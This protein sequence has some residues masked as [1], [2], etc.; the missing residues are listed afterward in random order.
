MGNHTDHLEIKEATQLNHNQ[1][2]KIQS[3][4]NHYV[5]HSTATFDIHIPSVAAFSDRMNSIA[6]KYPF[7]VCMQGSEI[8]G[9]AY[10]SEFRSKD[11][12]DKT[13]EL[14]IYLHPEVQGKG[15]G[16]LLMST[17]LQKLKEKEF[18]TAVSVVTQPNAASEKLHRKFGFISIGTLPNAGVKF[19]NNQSITFY[20]LDLR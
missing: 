9:Y 11:A 18:I 13:V 3:I 5:L 4:Y 6:A 17:L 7:L 20:Y 1:I 2:G 8:A 14:T 15:I 12:F 16:S 19:G 10:A